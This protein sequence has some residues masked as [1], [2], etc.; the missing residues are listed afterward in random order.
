MSTTATL[1]TKKKGKKRGIKTKEDNCG[2]CNRTDVDEEDCCDSCNL[3]YYRICVDLEDEND[4][5]ELTENDDVNYVCPLC[6]YNSADLI[7]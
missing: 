2:I 4:W 3:W 6:Q 7:Q 1:Y 5:K